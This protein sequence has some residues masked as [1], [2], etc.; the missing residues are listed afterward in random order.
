MWLERSQRCA[1][2]SMDL[3]M[4]SYQANNH[5]KLILDRKSYRPVRV[6]PALERD[7]VRQAC[8]PGGKILAASHHALLCYSAHTRMYSQIHAPHGECIF[9]SA[10]YPGRCRG[11]SSTFV[12][13]T[14]CR[15]RTSKLFVKTWM[16]CQ[17]TVDSAA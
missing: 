5:L 16:G 11:P 8:K 4:I 13:I 1:S 7:D 3:H 10:Y 12:H 2:L 15:P 17:H 9:S 14:G 6:Y